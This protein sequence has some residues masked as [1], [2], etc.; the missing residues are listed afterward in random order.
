L[1][2]EH[3]ALSVI[4]ITGASS[5]IGAA[6]AR[7][8]AA[9]GAGLVLTGRDR[10]RLEAVAQ[11]CRALGAETRIRLIDV[12]EREAIGAWIR[13]TD[14][15][16]PLD[17]VIV[18]AAVNGGH[19]SGGLETD[20]TAFETADINFTGALNVM[21]P[22]VTLMSERGRG[23]IA[24]ISS[25]AAYAPLPDAPAYSGA[26]AALLAHGLAL[27]QKLKPL[28]VRLSVVTP[29]YV[30]TPMGGVIKGWRPLEIT[31]D[32][33]AARIAGGLERDRDVIAFPAI[34]AALARGALLV[35]E[36]VRSAGLHG[37]RFR[38]RHRR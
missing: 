4:L 12:R 32:E 23:Q 13:E 28:G 24:L 19:P 16:T 29:G 20:A 35:P 22:C 7:F 5:G 25:L 11:G 21:L 1:R 30:K 37:F 33:A 10:E 34:L 8:Y 2:K 6:L 18:N 15:Q 9:R 17:L 36:W 27:R 38:N 14:A 3:A 31:A 26:K